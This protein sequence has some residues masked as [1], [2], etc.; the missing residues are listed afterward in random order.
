LAVAQALTG[1]AKHLAKV[2]ARSTAR[3]FDRPTKF[4]QRAFGVRM[5]KAADYRRGTMFS[6]V[7][8]KKYPGRIFEVRCRGRETHAEG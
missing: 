2:Q 8:A 1:T 3:H 6:R 7:F 4:T 5:A